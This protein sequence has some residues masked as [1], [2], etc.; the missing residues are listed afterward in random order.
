MTVPKTQG[1]GEKIIRKKICGKNFFSKYFLKK[2]TFSPG[3]YLCYYRKKDNHV[4]YIYS[5]N[6]TKHRFWQFCVNVRF[7]REY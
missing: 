1:E 6:P 7:L 5:I 3:K 4:D 2:C